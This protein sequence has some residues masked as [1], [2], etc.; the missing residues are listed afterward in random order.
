MDYFRLRGIGVSPGI[1]LGEVLLTERVIFTERKESISPHKVEEE[2]KRLKK[3]IKRT[4]GQLTQIKEQIKEKMGEEYSFIFE[5]HLLI[6]EGKSL[7]ANFER[8]I[9]EEN[10]RAEWALS[11]V[12]DKYDKLF[13]SLKDEYFKQRKSDITDVLARVYRNL[14]SVDRKREDEGREKILVSHELLPSEAAVKL[15]KGNVLAVALDMGGQTSHTAI[16]ARSL[17]VPAVVG[18]H[19]ISQKVKNGDTL[20][21]DGTDGEVLV[22]PPL[23]IRKEFL[24]KKQ[25]Y[26][27]YRKELKKTAK[28]SSL[29]L[30]DVSFSPLANI[31]LPEEV[32]LA[33]SLGAEGIGLFRSEFIY[34]QSTS[35]PSE[36]DHFSIYSRIAKE[37]YPHPVYIRTV[38]VGGEK[39]LP[40]LKI[41]KEPNPALGLRAIRFSLRDK[42][43]FKIQL[44]AI[45]RASIQ[46]NVKILFPMI[47]EIE[48][49]E[50]VKLLLREV[51][52]EL[53]TKRIKFD[54][55]IPLGVMIE[56]PAAAA[57]T[58]LLVK[59]VDYLSIGT[60]DL[61]QYY[62]AV[63]RSNEFVSYLYKPLHPSVL[64]LLKFII[65]TAHREGK[66]ITVCGEMA[67]DPLSAIALLGLGLKKFSMNPIFIPR[68]KKALRSVEHKTVKR[69]IQK[70]MTLRTAQEI[71]ECIIENI[72]AK[73]P[74]AFLM[75]QVI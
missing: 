66:E 52:D 26:N 23:A 45:L 46:K 7:H 74:K 53:K 60:N 28:L 19:N 64:R 13:E 3:A 21:V 10:C 42:D 69:V 49:V 70:A 44:R 58:D 17:D 61:I 35:L 39:N 73:H 27:D 5:A 30:D 31:E 11:R 34:F 68:I 32:N 24:S 63:D 8:I 29:T 12:H 38:D 2:L 36:E 47:T 54:E 18:L 6:L 56:V 14:E 57:I 67:A 65:E 41:E 71:E 33:L 55:K 62:L 48:E 16:L 9:K 37:A 50:E 40:Q 75:G 51:K 20:I 25:K 4:R 72:L 1:A 22:N 43:L 15:S 59:E